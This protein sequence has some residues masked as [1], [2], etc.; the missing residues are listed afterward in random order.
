M[1][2]VVC[3]SRLFAVYL[4]SYVQTFGIGRKF[5]FVISGLSEAPNDLISLAKKYGV[6]FIPEEE[7]QKTKYEELII[8]SY[9]QFHNQQRF[10]SSINFRTLTLYSDGVRNGFYGLPNL[11]P[12]LAKVI[13]FGLSLRETSFEV[14]IPNGFEQLVHEVVSL[15]QISITWNLLQQISGITIS[16][17]FT[18]NDLLIVMRYWG[19]PD[20]I[21]EFRQEISILDYLKEEF[22]RGYI[23]DR[24]IFRRDARFDQ[25]ISLEQLKK[26]FPHT[27]EF[28]MWEELFG[29]QGDFPELTE[30]ESVIFGVGGRPGYFF[31]FDS[32]LNVLVGRYWEKTKI[33]WPQPQ[34]FRRFFKFP[35]SSQHVEEQSIWM[36]AFVECHPVEGIVELKTS[37]LPI[38]QHLTQTSL[39]LHE[40]ERDALTQERDALTQERDALTQERDALTQ[41]RDALKNSTIWRATKSLRLVISWIKHKL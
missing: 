3:P 41:E 5:H 40:G 38:E 1:N 37:G 22:S 13:S 6:T 25:N 7:I 14:C 2:L 11:N 32:S 17:P 9:F 23:P 20:S 12:K 36:K 27:T 15:N 26:L 24:V 28:I 19:L 4:L 21:Y 8:H 30:P 18:S 10:I 35:R 29:S 33:L 39:R 34:V 31:G 16:N